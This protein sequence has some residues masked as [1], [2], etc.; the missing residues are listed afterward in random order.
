MDDRD[1]RAGVKFKDADLIGIP[2]RVTV[3]KKALAKNIVEVKLRKEEEVR[4]VEP[5]QVQKLIQELKKKGPES[6]FR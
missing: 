1:E 3:G 5:D 2:I 4:E 6:F